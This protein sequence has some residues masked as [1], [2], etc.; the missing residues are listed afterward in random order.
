L[1]AHYF[2]ALRPLRLLAA[3]T[4]FPACAA[5]KTRINKY[6]LAAKRRKQRKQAQ[7]AFEFFIPWPER[8]QKF[9][10][11]AWLRI[12]FLPCAFCASLRLKQAFYSPPLRLQPA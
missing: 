11:P 4:R 5:I 12:I 10:G 6:H 7:S 3:K 8:N 1:A 2:Y 9:K